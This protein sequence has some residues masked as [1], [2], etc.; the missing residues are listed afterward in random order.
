MKTRIIIAFL[1]LPVFS[2]CQGSINQSKATILKVVAANKSASILEQNDSLLS[3]S[4]KKGSATV[5]HIY[6]FDH[7]GKCITEKVVSACEACI[8]KELK[9]ILAI[10]RYQ[11]KKINENQYASKFEDKMIIELPV[12]KKDEYMILRTEWSRVL[13]DLLTGK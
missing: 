11:W 1:L 4:V 12:E 7:S 13:Y 2:F 8:A 9:A 3:V 5:K 6:S 10:S